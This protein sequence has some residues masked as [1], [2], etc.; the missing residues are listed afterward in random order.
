MSRLSADNTTNPRCDG[1]GSDWNADSVALVAFRMACRWSHTREDAEDIAQDAM[2]RFLDSAQPVRN[3]EPWFYVVTRRL[4]GRLISRR[5]DEERLQRSVS[6]LSTPGVPEYDS[7]LAANETVA[8]LA[9]HDRRILSL[10]VLGL[11]YGEISKKLGCPAN[12]VG[13]RLARARQRACRV[14]KST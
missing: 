12:Q 3:V 11:S 2:V 10:A 7:I 8:R 5:I 13:R 14:A 9:L 6:Q 4:A 1:V